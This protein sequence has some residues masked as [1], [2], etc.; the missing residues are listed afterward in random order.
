MD[1]TEQISVP[2]G[3]AVAGKRNLVSGITSPGLVEG[4]LL[5]VPV[6]TF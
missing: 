5:N 6:G 3:A 1:S 4:L 2:V